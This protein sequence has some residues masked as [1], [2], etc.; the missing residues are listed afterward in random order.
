MKKTIKT[1]VLAGILSAITVFSAGSMAMTTASAATVSSASVGDNSKF[2]S[3]LIKEE[4]ESVKTSVDNLKVSCVAFNEELGDTGILDGAF[5]TLDG[6]IRTLDTAS[7]LN[8]VI[9]KLDNVSGEITQSKYDLYNAMENVSDMAEFTRLFNTVHE[10][11]DDL[12]ASVKNIRK[13]GTATEQNKAIARYIGSPAEWSQT[14]N[15]LVFNFVSFGK[16]LSG[17]KKLLSNNKTIY[18]TIFNHYS[19]Q[20]VLGTEAHKKTARLVADAFLLYTKGSA[21]LTKC[22]SAEKEMLKSQS[23]DNNI[24]DICNSCRKIKEIANIGVNAK[25][26][27]S[28]FKANNT[29]YQFFDRSDK[30]APQRNIVIEKTLG[31]VNQG[32]V[33]SSLMSTINNGKF[34][35]KAQMEYLI[36]YVKTQYPGKSLAEF[37]RENGIECGN[38]N[39]LV[40]DAG[41]STTNTPG[42]SCRTEYSYN[43]IDL[44]DKNPSVSGN[45]N[46]YYSISRWL[47]IS[48]TNNYANADVSFLRTA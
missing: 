24:V 9:N 5:S 20:C 47:F 16:Y 13:F 33:D 11:I 14:N 44:N 23:M 34:I 43:I 39:L 35:G 29:P 21:I 38:G 42:G 4:E 3:E 45:T 31:K 32:N 46:L 30:T 25:K 6:V 17:E 10:Q 2:I 28:S 19:K 37:F 1:K 12:K 36:H 15:H 18:E 26:T 41:K 8:D 22:I 27:Y 48:D 40:S 7:T